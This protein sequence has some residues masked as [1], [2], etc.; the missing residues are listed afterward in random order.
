MV[1]FSMLLLYVFLAININNK[2]TYHYIV[3]MYN[4]QIELDGV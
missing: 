3:L 2:Y 4:E 1:N